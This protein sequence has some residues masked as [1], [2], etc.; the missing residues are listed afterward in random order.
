MLI[1]QGHDAPQTDEEK[2]IFESFFDPMIRE[3]A[4]SIAEGG[5]GSEYETSES[6]SSSLS[7]AR[8]EHER[9]LKKRVS[10]IGKLIEDVL[11]DHYN[12]YYANLA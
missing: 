4:Y 2:M 6:S 5:D 12:N 8:N 3:I 10:V 7:A 11:S 9:T 1:E